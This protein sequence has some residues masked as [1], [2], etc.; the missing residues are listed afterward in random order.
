MLRAI[1]GIKEHVQ[2]K[3]WSEMEKRCEEKANCYF[4]LFYSE[5]QGG[6]KEDWKV[7]NM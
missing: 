1:K 6:L 5:E 2:L 7:E 3:L 4:V